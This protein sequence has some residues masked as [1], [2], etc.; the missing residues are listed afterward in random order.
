MYIIYIH[1]CI[2]WEICRCSVVIAQVQSET[3]PAGRQDGKRRTSK[4]SQTHSM[5]QF[6]KSTPDPYPNIYTLIVILMV[7]PVSTVT[8]ERSFSAMRR[9]KN[10]LSLTTTTE[11]LSGLS[12]MYVHKDKPLDAAIIVQPFSQEKNRRLTFRVSP[13]LRN[14]TFCANTFCCCAYH[15]FLFI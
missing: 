5:I 2:Y 6:K 9:L 12:L 3:Q 7:M 4:G 13:V 15:L 1:V 8:A 14:I 11:R 10:Y